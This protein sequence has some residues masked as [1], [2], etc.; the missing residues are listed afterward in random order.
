ME[1]SVALFFQLYQLSTQKNEEFVPQM[2]RNVKP[3][4]TESPLSEALEEQVFILHHIV[5][6]GFG[7]LRTSWNIYVELRKDRVLP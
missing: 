3:S 2:G 7:Q 5:S 6:G 4:L 1:P